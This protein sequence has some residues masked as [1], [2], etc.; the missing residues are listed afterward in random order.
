MAGTRADAKHATLAL[1]RPGSLTGFQ[2]LHALYTGHPFV[3]V[4][5]LESNVPLQERDSTPDGLGV[6][7]RRFRSAS[8]VGGWESDENVA[9]LSDT[10]VPGVVTLT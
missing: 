1:W 2:R 10:F 6:P 8:A 3:K 5:V 9:T 7:N 4:L